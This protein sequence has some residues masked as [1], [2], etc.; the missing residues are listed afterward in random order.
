[1]ARRPGAHSPVVGAAARFLTTWVW[2]RCGFMMSISILVAV[3]AGLLAVWAGYYFIPYSESKHDNR[4][5]SFAPVR[6]GIQA[7]WFVDGQDYMSAVADAIQAA[8]NE[9]FITDWQLSP[10]IFMKRQDTGVD[11][12]AWRLDKMLFKKADE[13][14]SVYILLYWESEKIADMHLESKFAQSVLK[15]QNIRVLRHPGWYTTFLHGYAGTG[16]WSHHEKVVVVD[17]SIAFVGGI[18]LCFGRWD[19]HNHDLTDDYPLHPC[20]QENGQCEQD[21]DANGSTTRYSCWVGQDYGNTF[22]GGSRIEPDNLMKDYIHDYNDEESRNRTLR[23]CVPRMPWHDVACSFTGPPAHD[24]AKHFI[25]RYNSV[26]PWWMFWDL[27]RLNIG[28]MGRSAFDH[29]IPNPSANNL[30]IQVL[31][32]VDRWSAEQPREA[33]IYSAYLNA[34]KNAEH[35]IYIENQFFISSQPG[36]FLGVENQILAA[37]ADRIVH[38]FHNREDF[39]IMI[40][41]PLKPEFPGEWCSDSGKHL[42]AVSYWNYLSIY[43]GEDSLYNRLKKRG[44]SSINIL[45]F[46]TVYGLRTHGILDEKLV[47]EIIYVHSKIMI[48]DDKKAIIGSANINDRS[49]LGRKDSEMAVM[50]EDLDMIEGSMK[51]QHYQVGKFSHSLRCHLLREHL[52][53]LNEREYEASALKVEDPLVDDIHTAILELAVENTEIYGMVFGGVVEIANEVQDCKT[54]KEWRTMKGFAETKPEVAKKML[55]KVRGNIVIFP[56]HFLKERLTPSL[57]DA[58]GLHV[59]ARGLVPDT[60]NVIV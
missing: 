51:G 19:T 25:Q 33:S 13:N 8:K 6:N 54:Y 35:F 24:V 29:S 31:R 42:E 60:D 20:I 27:H 3:F 39:H 17:R 44:I 41:M 18:D 59:D 11:S 40:V 38:A 46:L 10:H 16:W 4:F 34:I 55:R 28:D 45:R 15:H 22:V 23:S 57:F 58:G 9:I 43:S 21:I 53:L 30:N 7:K 49:M 50:I 36:I 5:G 14:V 37:L 32:S 2:P 48:V 47:T 1:M 52:G 56:V 26:K 12:L